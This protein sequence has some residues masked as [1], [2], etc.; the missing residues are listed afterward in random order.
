MSY[1]ALRLFGWNTLKFAEAQF[2]SADRYCTSFGQVMNTDRRRYRSKV[3]ALVSV[4]SLTADAEGCHGLSTT[5]LTYRPR[6]LV[7]L[8]ARRRRGVHLQPTLSTSTARALC[9]LYTEHFHESATHAPCACG[10]L[11]VVE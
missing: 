10:L 7:V 11:S 4:Q 1:A 5:D 8:S 9:N 3:T 6:S 2:L